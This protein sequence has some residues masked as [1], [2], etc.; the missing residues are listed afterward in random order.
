MPVPVRRRRHA[1][2]Q[3]TS[4]SEGTAASRSVWSREPPPPEGFQA[5]LQLA[6]ARDGVGLELSGPVPLGPLTIVA[7]RSRMIGVGF[8]LDVSGGVDRFRHRRTTLEVAD[9]AIEHGPLERW[10]SSISEGL[11]ARS[12]C[13]V[14]VA[15]IAPP[16]VGTGDAPAERE[17]R[18]VWSSG[19]VRVELA[20]EDAIVAFDLAL[21]P[22]GGGIVALAHRVRA[23][24]A[25]RA[26]SAI[27]GALLSRVA[28]N[29]GGEARGLRL[30]V[31]DPA[32]HAMFAAFVARGA[33][34][35]TRE[36]L[37]VTD[38]GVDVE[39]FRIA[40]RRGG[41]PAPPSGVFV[42]LDELDRLIGQG[43]VA[44][45]E[46][47]LDKA[48]DL[49]LR[50]LDRAPRQRSILTRLAEVDAFTGDRVEAAASWLRD[51]QRG[52]GRRGNDGNEL[53]R[54]LLAA[55]L[56]ERAQATGRARATWE[57]AGNDAFERGEARLAAKAW[58]RAAALCG[59]DEALFGSLLDRALSADPSEVDARWRRAR[60]N[61]DFGDDE[62]ALED[63][64]HLEAQA[65]GREPRRRTLIRAAR[66]WFEAGRPERAIAAWE[67]ALRH[68]PE[69]RDVVAGLGSSLL[70]AGAT[71]RGIALLAHAFDLPGD[72]V[73]RSP[74]A[75][76]LARALAERMGDH[77]AAVARL[78]EIGPDDPH[79]AHAR[80]LEGACRLQ[81]GDGPGAERAYA[82][83]ADLVE[84]RPVPAEDAQ[85]VR[86]LLAGGARVAREEGRA[87]FA[88]RLA[89]AALTVA[90]NDPDARA[91]VQAIGRMMP[92][93][94]ERPEE[95][96]E[97][98][99]PEDS[100]TPTTDP[101]VVAGSALDLDL[102]D[103]PNTPQNV[104]DETRAEALLARVKADPQDHAAIDALVEVLARL[105]RDMEMFALLSARW[106]DA[107]PEE[108]RALMPQQRAVLA[109]L[110]VAAAKNGRALE[111]QLYRDALS[112]LR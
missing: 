68:L 76:E 54:T 73:G 34:V 30:V 48:R 96:D 25:K 37:V 56:A 105:G 59:D 57:R 69:D 29:I 65:K 66:M 43:D 103:E 85:S 104:D 86:E 63:V 46:G 26:P 27:V 107:T 101:G 88:M 92:A 58:T 60:L 108:R 74:I 110:A 94:P 83:A 52:R 51:A 21:A 93:R 2:S 3:S 90:P 112:M 13:E 87:S 17:E 109:R 7:A 100:E 97:H 111:A 38:T 55:W 4:G 35:P 62:G 64:Q 10:L 53:G 82:A 77:P 23:T 40:M 89:L 18:V 22:V 14:R 91:L 72:A 24:G 16:D 78:R 42:A 70:A 41:T 75:I 49:Y 19:N 102:D 67:R 99:P 20:A 80:A 45:V 9:V 12:T 31:A 79:A 8:P 5:T 15:W 71:A 81:L 98:E 39:R 61:I 84:H 47:A 33:R 50:A 6:I 106:D 28:R 11:V 1:A 36:G 44:L 95:D 32:K